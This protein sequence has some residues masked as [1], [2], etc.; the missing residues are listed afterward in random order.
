MSR[1]LLKQLLA[2]A[3]I[4]TVSL[5]AAGAVSAA[6]VMHAV[7][8]APAAATSPVQNVYWVRRHGH[9][10]WVGRHHR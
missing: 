10:Y 6:P 3:V 5:G 4:A 7:T 2:T 8:V 9:R 1:L